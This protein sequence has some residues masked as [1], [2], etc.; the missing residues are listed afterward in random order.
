M[1]MVKQV[2]A[3]L[4]IASDTHECIP[5]LLITPDPPY[6]CPPRNVVDVR[7]ATVNR[8]LGTIGILAMDSYLGCGKVF[9]V[10]WPSGI[11]LDH[12]IHYLPETSST[13]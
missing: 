3:F 8:C 9:S 2:E 13:F 4:N 6:N 10:K 5:E 11:L 7:G 1:D 12:H